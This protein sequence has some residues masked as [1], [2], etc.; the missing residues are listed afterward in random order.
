MSKAATGLGSGYPTGGSAE[1]GEGGRCALQLPAAAPGLGA[2]PPSGPW[3]RPRAF[4]RA[5]LDGRPFHASFQRQP[6]GYGYFFC[7]INIGDVGFY[8]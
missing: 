8:T 4:G 3:H 2:Q 7:F 6:H 5:R 1:T